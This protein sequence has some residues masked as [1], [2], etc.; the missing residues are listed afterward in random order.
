[1][2]Q[3][4]LLRPAG[5]PLDEVELLAEF[6]VLLAIRNVAARRDIDVFDSDAA[7]E[8]DAAM[9]RLPFAW[10]SSR[11]SSRQGSLLMMATPWCM[12]WPHNT[13][14]SYPSRWNMAFGK[15][16]VDDLGFL[17]AKDVGPLL[18]EELLDDVEAGTDGIDVPGSN[19]E[20][21]L[22]GWDV[23]MAPSLSRTQDMERP[24]L[25]GRGARANQAF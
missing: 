3:P 6:R 16:A 17:E 10:K 2:G 12:R 9:A 25:R 23:A 13:T 22:H 8:P 20:R 15:V 11:S 18:D 19:G 7:I 21:G 5:H 1:V 14:W 24:P 4:H